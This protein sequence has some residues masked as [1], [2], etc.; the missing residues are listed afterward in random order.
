MVGRGRRVLVV[1]DDAS[2]RA[3]LTDALTQAGYEVRAAVGA[4]EGLAA[5]VGWHPDAIVLDLVLPAVDGRAFTRAVRLDPVL[6]RTPILLLAAA[7]NDGLPAA[8]A[9][10]GADAEL[11]KPP[12]VEE[13]LALVARLAG[14]IA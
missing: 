3:L 11:A 7:Q 5:V 6:G 2:T 4:R 12:V 9:R 8:E 13:L 1:E 14:P 10:V